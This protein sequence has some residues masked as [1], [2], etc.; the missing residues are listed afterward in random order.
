MTKTQEGLEVLMEALYEVQTTIDHYCLHQYAGTTI[1]DL[2]EQLA[3][4]DR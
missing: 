4:E 1:S 2:I 3:E